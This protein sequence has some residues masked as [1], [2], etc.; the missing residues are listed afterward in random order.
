M[1]WWPDVQ[2]LCR[3]W[4]R[5]FRLETWMV[6]CGCAVW[7]AA[8]AVY[9][10]S[11]LLNAPAS[12]VT[13]VVVPHAHTTRLL[14]TPLPTHPLLACFSSRPTTVLMA[15]ISKA[16]QAGLEKGRGL[17]LEREPE[18]VAAMQELNRCVCGGGVGAI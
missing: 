1:Q 15:A 5:P 9:L 13:A 3:S 14:P 16:R 8:G 7:G 2:R 6:G 11:A 10:L 12:I 18:L 17:K 4:K